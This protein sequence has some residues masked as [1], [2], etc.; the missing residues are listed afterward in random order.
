MAAYGFHLQKTRNNLH[1]TSKQ[2][3]SGLCLEGQVDL[4]VVPKT[5]CV[6][7]CVCVLHAYV[8]VHRKD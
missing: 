5:L 4:C 7:V 1:G 3:N 8:S 2:Q 6:C